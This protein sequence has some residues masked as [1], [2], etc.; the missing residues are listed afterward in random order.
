MSKVVGAVN[1]FFEAIE[2]AK[3][4]LEWF[5]W[6]QLVVSISSSIGIGVWA[7]VAGLPGPVIATCGFVF[8]VAALFLTKARAFYELLRQASP[9]AEPSREWEHVQE[10]YL[11]QAAFL[12]ANIE[13]YETS[14]V[15][16]GRVMPWFQTLQNAVSSGEITR[17]PD[18]QDVY[19]MVGDVYR[20]SFGT[21][22]GREELRK[23][24]K[25]YD[26][27]PHFLFPE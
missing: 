1:S 27:R 14:L 12:F 6:T 5:G 16:R 17:I 2:N 23:F 22:V 9:H 24:A 11:L 10:F 3:T 7:K 4:L 26:K 8:L 13:P 18:P 25:K 20:P 15:P 19:L 21:K